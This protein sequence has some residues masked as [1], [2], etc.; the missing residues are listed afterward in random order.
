MYLLISVG[1]H[2]WVLQHEDED[3]G[4]GVGGGPFG[5]GGVDDLDDPAGLYSSSRSKQSIACYCDIATFKTP[6]T[7]LR[8]LLVV[9]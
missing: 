6:R 9:S 1:D 4:D 3:E 8:V 7:L 2:I 5:G